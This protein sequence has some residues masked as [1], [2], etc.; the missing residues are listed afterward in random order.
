MKWLKASVIA[1][2]CGLLFAAGSLEAAPSD[3]DRDRE[4]R[5]YQADRDRDG[6]Q[7]TYYHG[8]ERYWVPQQ[9]SR[10]SNGQYWSS[11]RDYYSRDDDYYR[12]RQSRRFSYR[13]D[14]D[15]DDDRR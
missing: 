3:H 1:A 11:P 10:T 13:R 4:A 9:H 14:R 5:Q 2:G 7:S 8:G 12:Y 15:D 6:R